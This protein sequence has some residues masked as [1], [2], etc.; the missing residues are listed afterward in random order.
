LS[1]QLTLL[2]LLS[3]YRDRRALHSFPTRRSSDLAA[4]RS[5]FSADRQRANTDSAI[6]V[7]GT[8]KSRATVPVH[9]P[10]PFCPAVSRILSTRGRDRKSTRLNSSHVKISYAVFC[11][12][13]K[14]N[15]DNY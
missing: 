9:L 13:K 7:R 15:E 1:C 3:S 11:L 14:R 4:T 2:Y 10:V 5:S 6:S 12:K 8:P